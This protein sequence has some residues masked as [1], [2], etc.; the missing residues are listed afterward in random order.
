VETLTGVAGW[1]TAMN[2]RLALAVLASLW[3]AVPALAQTADAMPVSIKWEGEDEIGR[4]L[5]AKMRQLVAD[6]LS[7]H[8]GGGLEIDEISVKTQN[9]E[10]ENANGKSAASFA[11]TVSAICGVGTNADLRVFHNHYVRVVTNDNMEATADNILT[12]FRVFAGALV[13]GLSECEIVGKAQL[14]N[15]S[16]KQRRKPAADR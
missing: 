4:L 14:L 9:V 1:R 15:Q 6:P 11:F 8:D 7:L 3:T 12:H 13:D 2:M 5:T 16:K 10:A